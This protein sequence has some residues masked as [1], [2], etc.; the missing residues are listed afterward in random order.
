MTAQLGA[1]GTTV[2]ISCQDIAGKLLYTISDVLAAGFFFVQERPCSKIAKMVTLDLNTV[3][4]TPE[5][6]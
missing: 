6:S 4:H 1:N 3:A 2:F 5:A